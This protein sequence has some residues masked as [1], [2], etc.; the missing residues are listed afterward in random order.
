LVSVTLDRHVFPFTAIVGQES[1]K[2]A[3]I[4]NAIVPTI[5]GVLIRG[6]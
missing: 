1:M 2:L 4:L 6:E 5:G 3:L